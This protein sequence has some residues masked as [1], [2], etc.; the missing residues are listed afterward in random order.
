MMAHRSH[1]PRA[2]TLIEL[3]V[4]MGIMG[5]LVALLLPAVQ[6]ARESSRRT[7]CLNNLK[8]IGLALGQYADVHKRLPPASTSGVDFGVWSYAYDPDVHLHS[9]RS[10]I[11]PFVEGQNLAVNIDYTTSSLGPHNRQPAATIVQLYRCPSFIGEPFTGEPLYHAIGSDFAI[12]NYLAM[13]A[14][15]VGSLWSPG[16]DG[17]RHPNGV[18]YCLSDTA[19]KDIT[20]GL[21]RTIFVVE[22]REQNAAVWI[23]GTAAAAVAHPFDI[24][25]VPEYARPEI[26]LNYT[27]Y[28]E[29]GDPHDSIDSLYGPSSM[30]PAVVQHLFGD[31]SARGISEEV[32]R[33][34]Y[35]ALVTR[36]GDE[37][38]SPLP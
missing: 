38:V 24:G 33:R 34:L 37:V 22:T 28:Y 27:P 2:F 19:P 4:V 30:H 14:T 20:D 36:A 29:Y 13:G 1:T 8:Q 15:T 16:P 11:L 10:L 32:D 5:L 18:M 12:A 9:W 26:S 3:L 23:D 6:A 7:H 25:V 31:G 17:R 21:S 35:D